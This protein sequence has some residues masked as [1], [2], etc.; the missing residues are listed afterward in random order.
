VIGLDKVRSISAGRNH[1]LAILQSGRARS[2]GA[3]TYGQLGNGASG[4]A[5]NSDVPVGIKNLTTVKNID[6]GYI[7]TLAATE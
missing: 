5:A 2:W 7:H 1:S 4:S 6:G 3:N